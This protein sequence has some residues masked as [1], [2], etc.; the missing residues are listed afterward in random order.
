VKAAESRDP[1]HR[2][3]RLSDPAAPGA[4]PPN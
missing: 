1:P 2:L 4:P 3:G